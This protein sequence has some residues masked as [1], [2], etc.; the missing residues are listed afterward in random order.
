MKTSNPVVAGKLA[1]AKKRIAGDIRMINL[2][3][4][5]VCFRRQLPVFAFYR[6]A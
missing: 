1:S 2:P 5:S 3:C 6:H 4:L